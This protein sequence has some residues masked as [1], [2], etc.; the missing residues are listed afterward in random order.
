MKKEKIFLLVFLLIFLSEIF[1]GKLY[2]EKNC[3]IT[4][5][6]NTE[7]TSQEENCYFSNITIVHKNQCLITNIEIDFIVP[8][9]FVLLAIT[10]CVNINIV[11]SSGIINRKLKFRK[12][13]PR[14]NL[15]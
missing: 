13:M 9:L 15:A 11:F 12:Q 6:P 2:E 10:S 14:G 5:V 8:V 7:E 4:S 3:I 1:I